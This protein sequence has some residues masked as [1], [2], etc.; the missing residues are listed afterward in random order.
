MEERRHHG[1]AGPRQRHQHTAGEGSNPEN[2][3]VV[4]GTLFLSADDGSTGQELWKSDGS[5]RRAVEDIEPAGG[6]E[7]SFPRDL[8]GVGSTLLF[9]VETEAPDSELWKSESPY[10]SATSVPRSPAGQ[11]KQVGDL[12]DVNGTLFLTAYDN[13][14]IGRQN[15]LW[16]SAAPF[17]AVTAMPDLTPDPSES[18]EVENLTNVNGTLF[19]TATNGTSGIELWKLNGGTTATTVPDADGIN[20]G[21]GDS[22][23]SQLTNVNGT[24]FFTADDGTTGFEP[25]RTGIEAAPPVTA[26]CAGKKATKVGTKGKNKIIGTKK[27]DVI[28]GLGGND[29]I[30]GKGGNDIICGGAGKDTLIGGKGKDKLLGGKGN[31]TLKGG[32]GKDKLKGGPGNDI[33]RQ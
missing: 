8:T 32:P 7:S 27:A 4:N 1:D 28:A 22:S 24:L 17:T 9:S 19:F 6:D 10:T 31:D 5:R 26:K 11:L 12:T 13:G 18:S 14:T 30:K 2:L 15:E 29:T 33:Q 25:W 16:K 20:P 21:G 3:T 23:P